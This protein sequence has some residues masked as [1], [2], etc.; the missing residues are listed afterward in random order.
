MTTAGLLLGG[1]LVATSG[2][3]VLAPASV[4]GP[5][6]C[7]LHPGDYRARARP[8]GQLPAHSTKGLERQ[9]VKPGA[10]PPGRE[11]AVADYWAQD[12]VHSAAPIV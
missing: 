9:H 11:L 2:V 12:P 7:R 3:T 5:P 1:Q 6:R 8:P 4:G 10:G